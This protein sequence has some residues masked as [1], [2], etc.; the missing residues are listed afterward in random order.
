[1]WCET[2]APLP[3]RVDSTSTWFMGLTVELH[4]SKVEPWVVSASMP[5]R[6]QML[7]AA[8]VPS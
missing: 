1:M 7:L 8:R 5:E 6:L 2:D 3:N 4:A